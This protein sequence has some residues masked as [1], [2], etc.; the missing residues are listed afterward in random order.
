MLDIDFRKLLVG[1]CLGLATLTS[2]QAAAQAGV[3]NLSSTDKSEVLVIG[4]SMLAWHKVSGRSIGDVIS[5]KLNRTVVDRSIV[6]ARF[7]YALPIS[8]AMGLNI[9]KQYRKGAWDWV[10]INGGG[11]DL[12]FGCG[13]LACDGVIDRLITKDGSSGKIP[14]LVTKIQND[15][16]NVIFVGYL[17]SPGV[18]S[19]IDHCRDE[20]LELDRRLSALA[21]RN[22]RLEFISLSGLIPYGDKSFHSLDMIHPS[23]K[24]SSIIGEKI[25]EVIRRKR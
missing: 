10:V 1:L 23:L 5:R 6:A 11:N 16:A 15:G 25:A 20:G 8:G 21:S 24:G 12:W 19:I 3:T 7:N 14:K 17:H 2:S 18:A 22:Q 13:C 4:D 9:S